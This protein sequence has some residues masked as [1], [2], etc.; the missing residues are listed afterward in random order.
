[1]STLYK[2]VIEKSPLPIY[3]LQNGYFQLVNQQTTVMTGYTVEELLQIPFAELI[4]PEDR[5]QVVNNALQRLAGATVPESYEFRAVAKN[6]EVYFVRGYF[7]IIEYEG[8]PA[9]LGQILNITEQKKAEKALRESE[10][11]N[12]TVVDNASEAILVA[13]DG[14]IK[15]VNRKAR[16]IIRYTRRE[17]T[18]R[19]F[20]EFIH[21]DDREMVLNS[22]LKR[23]K[24]EEP[25]PVYP[26]R[27]LDK[28]GKIKWLEIN[29]VAFT[30]EGKPAILSF[31]NDITGRKLAEE[32]LVESEARLRRITDNMLDVINQIDP[33]GIIQYASPSCK[34]VLGY[35]PEEMLGRS[36]FEHIHPGDLVQVKGAF[37]KGTG[38]PQPGTLQF[39]YRH[40]GGHYLW[41]ESICNPLQEEDGTVSGAILCTRDIT[42]RKRVEDELNIQRAYFQQLFE[43]SPQGI[44]V[45]D[46]K[47]IVINANRG[48]K[49]L[50]QYS[51]EEIKGLSLN[52]IIVPEDLAGEANDLSG[53]VLAGEIVQKE[54]V[55]KRKDGSLVNVSILGYPIVAGG[56]QVGIFAIYNDITERKQ[57]EERLKFLSLRDPLTGLYNRAFF[58]QEMRRLENDGQSGSGI[59]ICDVDGLKLAN[60]SFGHHTGDAL[61]LAAA[62]VIR[63]S[64]RKDD[65]VARIGGDEFAVLLPKRDRLFVESAARRIQ[66]AVKR[67]NLKNPELPLSISLGF[68]A[69]N[70]TLKKLSDLFK[71]ADNNMYREKLHRSKIVRSAAVQA[72]VKALEAR[73]FFAGGHA[74]RLCKLA[75]SLATAV[76]LPERRL[77]GLRLLAKFHDLGKVGIPDRILFKTS[78]LS[79]EEVNEMKRHCEIG[80]RIAQ[81]APDLAPIADWILKHHEWWNGGG[82]PLGL[83]GEAIPLECRI[84]AIADAYDAM[85]SDRPY[86]KAVTHEEAVAELKKCSGTQFEPFLVNM[87]IKTLEKA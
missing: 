58:E 53:L 25:P 26:F 32:K 60:D 34:T 49:N 21:P 45:L 31:L 77:A 40:A 15:F 1:M 7:S 2:M 10:E 35:D 42:G 85:T 86:R 46:N 50:F 79:P 20:V 36:V 5:E 73:D 44:A 24:G 18:S 43:N 61:L 17:L 54:T 75:V 87:F 65:I 48:F 4:H 83:K 64:F 37:Q 71:E 67:H 14:M 63:D 52:N 47:S 27:I 38:I 84:L 23:L 11:K 82:Y 80:H 12:R 41:L 72:L 3:V 30:W 56:E 39:R 6:G 62:R 16:E 29:S 78:P 9:V 28:E 68:A 81:S 22:Y 59:I 8:R 55:R 70:G 69:T 33:G 51:L 13:Q 74:D 57:A 66:Y 76:G 19:P